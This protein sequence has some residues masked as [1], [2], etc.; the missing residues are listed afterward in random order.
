ML[1]SN[2]SCWSHCPRPVYAHACF[3]INDEISSLVCNVLE[4]LHATLQRDR[5]VFSNYESPGSETTGRSTLLP[6]ARDERMKPDPSEL[7][8]DCVSQCSLPTGYGRSSNYANQVD[9]RRR[10]RYARIYAPHPSKE[11]FTTTWV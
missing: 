7:L 3:P 8:P 10:K 9:A 2:Y 11:C 5:N 1:L 6:F 4:L